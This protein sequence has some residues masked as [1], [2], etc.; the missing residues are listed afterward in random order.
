MLD[1]TLEAIYRP[2]HL[3]FHVV[4]YDFT[5]NALRIHEENRLLNFNPLDSYIMGLMELFYDILLL[6]YTIST[7]EFIG[8]L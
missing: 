3:F 2:L 4:Y 1:W 8:A 6:G 7:I 5:S